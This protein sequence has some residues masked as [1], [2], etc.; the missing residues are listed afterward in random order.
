MTR[1]FFALKGPR[2]RYQ[3][4]DS[5]HAAIIS[6]WTLSGVK[7]EDVIGESARPWTFAPVQYSKVGGESHVSGLTISTPDPF[8]SEALVKMEAHAISARS[9]NGD[10]ITFAGAEKKML[11]DPITDAHS[12]ISLCFASPFVVMK[13][14]EGRTKTEFADALSGLDLSAAFSAGL[15]KRAGRAVIVEV[16]VD[17]LTLATDG[18]PRHVY[19]RRQKGRRVTVPAFALPLTLR[20]SAEDLRFAYFAGLG[21]KTRNGFGC[22]ATTR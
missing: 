15:S 5:I 18:K 17:G 12:E 20:G 2:Q 14:K 8:L 13:P 3:F 7:P 4:L 21:A 9:C 6:G 16:G 10:V 22:P 1:A 11:D 19:T